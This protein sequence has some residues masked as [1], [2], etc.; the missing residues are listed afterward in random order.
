MKLQK[1]KRAQSVALSILLL[2][3]AAAIILPHGSAQYRSERTYYDSSDDDHSSGGWGS[4]EARSRAF[5]NGTMWLEVA[6]ATWSWADSWGLVTWSFQPPYTLYNVRISAD[7]VAYG[8]YSTWFASAHLWF[9]LEAPG[10]SNEYY[11]WFGNY[12]YGEINQGNTVAINNF[13]TMYLGTVYTITARIR[14]HCEN[15]AFVDLESN[16]PR[17]LGHG[18]YLPDYE[19]YGRVTR[20]VVEEQ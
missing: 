17:P 19:G 8:Q 14:I 1:S 10:A 15:G 4:R 16:G 18:Q 5:Q 20:I 6:A 9:V 11:R 12:D 3:C 13:G 2:A 7:F